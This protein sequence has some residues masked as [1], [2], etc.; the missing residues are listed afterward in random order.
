V[1]LVT[2]RDSCSELLYVSDVFILV[3]E[4]LK[5]CPVLICQAYSLAS[6]FRFQCCILM[7]MY[8]EP[9]KLKAFKYLCVF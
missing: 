1:T 6:K 2:G 8:M 7:V 5:V 3:E 4:I 9:V